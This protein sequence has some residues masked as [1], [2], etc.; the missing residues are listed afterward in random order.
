[1]HRQ[2]E[3]Y[4]LPQNTR[5]EKENSTHVTL[6]RLLSCV[7]S[8]VF[9]EAPLL[10]EGLAALWAL[11]G[12]LLQ[13][14]G[15]EHQE[16]QRP[17]DRALSLQRKG[18]CWLTEC[19]DGRCPSPAVQLAAANAHGEVSCFKPSQE[20]LMTFPSS[21]RVLFIKYK[22]IFLCETFLVFFFFLL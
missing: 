21:Y 6:K 20:I 9:I 16:G 1:M 19:W 2:R 13:A 10:A 22:R 15:R 3:S 11:V 8:L 17:S 4:R 12:L 14:R 7:R 18:D 5:E